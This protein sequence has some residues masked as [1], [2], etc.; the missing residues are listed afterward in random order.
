MRD[1]GSCT[2]NALDN[3]D[4]GKYISA[5]LG[6]GRLGSMNGFSMLY[7]VTGTIKQFH[8]LATMCSMPLIFVWF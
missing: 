6:L 1:N 5:Y 2:L 7:Y 4:R 8:W 3:W